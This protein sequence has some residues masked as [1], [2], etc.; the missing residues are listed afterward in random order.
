MY[1]EVCFRHRRRL[2]VEQ[3]EAADG[4]RAELAVGRQ[5]GRDLA[6]KEPRAAQNGD[7]HGSLRAFAELRTIAGPVGAQI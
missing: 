1:W 3:R 4:R 6:A 7:V 5:A 2:Q